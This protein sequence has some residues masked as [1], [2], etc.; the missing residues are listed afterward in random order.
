MPRTATD[1]RATLSSRAA[2]L[3]GTEHERCIF[4]NGT[5]ITREGKRY[6]KLEA[7][8]LWYCRTCDRV[9]TPQRAR[10]KTYPL[11]II[12]ES[13]MFYYRGETRVRTAQRVK[14][15][16]GIVVPSRTLSAWLSE[17]RE[18]TTYAPLFFLWQQPVVCR[19]Y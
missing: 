6:K 8:Q 1:H 2:R 3:V 14:E 19:I 18:L 15:R 16:F 9:F 10:G 12:L 7:V 13:L 4:C 17:Y 11:K 5:E